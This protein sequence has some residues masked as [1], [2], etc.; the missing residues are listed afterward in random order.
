MHYPPCASLFFDFYN[1]VF[2]RLHN[3]ELSAQ[4]DQR[5][6]ANLDKI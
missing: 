5:D 6:D 3:L 4:F 2:K 1:V